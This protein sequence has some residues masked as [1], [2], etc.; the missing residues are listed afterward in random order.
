MAKI[1]LGVTG[2]I[3][4]YKACDLTSKLVQNGHE[5]RIVLSDGAK[6]FVGAATFEGLTSEP[7][8]TSGFEEG[9]RM[10]HIHWERW[11]DLIL[12]YPATANTI[13]QMS[14]GLGS[15]LLGMIFLAHE[16]RKDGSKPFWIAPA[17]NPFML[18]HPATRGSLEKLKSWGVKVLESTS[19]RTACGEEGS[20]RLVEPLTALNAIENFFDES[21]RETQGKILITAGGTSEAI[22][23]VRVL[24]NTSTG[25][26]GIQIAQN[27]KNAGFDVTLLLSQSSTAASEIDS[28]MKV[29]RFSDFMSLQNLIKEELS[30]SH[31]EMVIHAA[32]VSDFSVDHVENLK[33]EKTAQ[34]QKIHS[35]EGIRIS[36]KPNPKIV[37]SLREYSKN[38]EIR[39]VSFKLTTSGEAPD[40]STYDSDFI[41]HN[42]L[43]GISRGT[44]RHEGS[45]YSRAGEM[46][47]RFQ[48]N[49]NLSSEILKLAQG[50]LGARL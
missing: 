15:D 48:T 42:D 12:V 28:N 45:I 18:N 2:S 47:C 22:D 33:G 34:H 43:N 3:A 44:D 25:E 49:S 19:G 23:P 7:V 5:V 40:L 8:L 11:A 9:N 26:T 37:H 50:D 29:L 16:F 46:L 17:M 31:F 41:V 14:Q 36:L 24:T 32:A 38:K 35:G 13:N 4:A 30:H 39:V 21:M 1:L 6:N 20:G 27:L 10:A